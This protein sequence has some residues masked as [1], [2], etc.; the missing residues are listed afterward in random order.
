MLHHLQLHRT[1]PPSLVQLDLAGS[2]SM[3]D[4][5]PR[6]AP[7]SASP[8]PLAAGQLYGLIAPSVRRELIG[9][10]DSTGIHW[11]EGEIGTVGLL[12]YSNTVLLLDF[13]NRRLATVPSPTNWPALLGKGAVVI[14]LPPGATGQ[15]VV[16]IVDSRGRTL[17]G[18]FD[19]GLSPFPLWATHAAWRDLTGLAGPGP[20]T[21]VY[22]IPNP[23][24]ELVFV[25]APL[26][27]RLHI[28]SWELRT[29]EVVYLARGPAG[30]PLEEWWSQVDFVL[31]PALFAQAAVVVIDLPKGR[32]GLGRRIVP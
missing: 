14:A 13:V 31:G 9:A 26:R 3:P 18:L 21:R 4:G 2:G 16:P 5:F 10:P 24:G 29:P 8:A 12:N 6:T 20:G 11:Q 7:E 28:G 15:V 27:Q 1:G 17:R 25:G 32:F 23:N 30:A 22:R 19:T